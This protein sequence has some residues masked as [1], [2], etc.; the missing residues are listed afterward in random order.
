MT[1]HLPGKL[2]L[3]MVSKA[4]TPFSSWLLKPGFTPVI[5]KSGSFSPTPSMVSILGFQNGD[6]QFCRTRRVVGSGLLEGQS[7]VSGSAIESVYG[8][9]VFA[10]TLWPPLLQKTNR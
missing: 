2:S 9:S 4:L 6:A 10:Q 5:L 7:I 8:P 3:V 1:F